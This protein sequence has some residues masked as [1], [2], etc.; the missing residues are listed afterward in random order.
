MLEAKNLDEVLQIAR[1]LPGRERV[2]IEVRPVV[3]T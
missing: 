3:P 2:T 1:E